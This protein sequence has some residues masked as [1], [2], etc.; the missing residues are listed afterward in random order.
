M[1]IRTIFFLISAIIISCSSNMNLC[2][3][4][5][6]YK[7]KNRCLELFFTD[8]IFYYQNY[9]KCNDIDTVLRRTIIWGYY[10]QNEDTI[11]LRNSDCLFDTCT[12]SMEFEYKKQHS[13]DCQFLNIERFDTNIIVGERRYSKEFVRGMIPNIDIDTLFFYRNKLLLLKT[14][15]SRQISIPFRK[16]MLNF[17]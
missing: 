3:S 7:S 6:I 9:F 8:S 4:T 12:Y 14:S 15:S 16:K 17:K 11:F 1:Q 10:K 5:Y 13:R 2:D